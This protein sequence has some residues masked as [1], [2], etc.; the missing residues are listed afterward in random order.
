M[1]SEGLVNDDGELWAGDRSYLRRRLNRYYDVD[2]DGSLW[3]YADWYDDDAETLR[4]DVL[5]YANGDGEHLIADEVPQ[6][7]HGPSGA[8][9]FR[10]ADLPDQERVEA[11]IAE[12][13]G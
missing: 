12:V 11:V 7:G 3:Y 5:V 8:I 1:S 10:T 6:L 13:R 9:G 4:M 2:E